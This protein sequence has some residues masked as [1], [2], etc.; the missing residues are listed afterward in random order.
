MKLIPN[1]SIV[2]SCGKLNIGHISMSACC[3]D[4]ELNHT[5]VLNFQNMVSLL[6]QAKTLYHA[7]SISEAIHLMRFRQLP[8]LSPC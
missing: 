2:P 3:L 7:V 8:S 4:T 5:E 6:T 1:C